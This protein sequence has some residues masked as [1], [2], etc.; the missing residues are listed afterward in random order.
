[1]AKM[2]FL[3][4][5]I[6]TGSRS[7]ARSLAASLS[8]HTH[9]LPP[10]QSPRGRKSHKAPQQ[11]EKERFQRLQTANELNAAKKKNRFLKKEKEK[12][13]ILVGGWQRM[14]L[15]VVVVVV[16]VTGA[17]FIHFFIH[18]RTAACARSIFWCVFLSGGKCRSVPSLCWVFFFVVVFVFCEKLHTPVDF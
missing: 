3:C 17:Q 10:F 13:L 4:V 16:V 7:L 5:N 15:P 14:S 1:M 12:S 9:S 2:P 11:E 8:P 6:P 18:F